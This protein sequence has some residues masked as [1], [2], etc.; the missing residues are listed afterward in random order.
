VL[1]ASAA[2]KLNNVL[3]IVVLLDQRRIRPEIGR[4]AQRTGFAPWRV[5]AV[6][7]RCDRKSETAACAGNA[8]FEIRRWGPNRRVKLETAAKVSL[9]STR[10]V[11]PTLPWLSQVP[12][13]LLPVQEEVAAP[14]AFSEEKS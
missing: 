14:I 7:P 5:S 13:A 10:Q 3:R 12:L 6:N 11:R 1:A 4:G 2:V 8:V 9:I